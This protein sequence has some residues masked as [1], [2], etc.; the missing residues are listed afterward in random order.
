MIQHPNKKKALI[1]GGG[2]AG[3]TAAV[4]LDEM[5]YRITLLEAKPTL[6]GRAYSFLDKKTGSPV[7]NGQHVMIGAYHETIKLLERVG[8]KHTIK[9]LIPTRI[10]IKNNNNKTTYFCLRPL[11]FPFNLALAFLTFKG[12][13]FKDKINLLKL[14]KELHR[15]KTHKSQPPKQITVQ[16]WLKKFNQSKDAIQN[17]W[18]PLTLATLNNSVDVAAAESLC[19][20]FLK[21]YCEGKNDGLLIIPKKPL[22]DVFANPISQYIHM[23]GH[24][25]KLQA[26]VT[27]ISFLDHKVQSFTLSNGDTLKADLYISAMPPQ[28]L[29]RVLPKTFKDNHPPLSKL[30]Q[31]QKS[32]II[33]VDLFYD[34]CIMTDDFIGSACTTFQW[35]FRKTTNK[36]LCHV[37]G[38]ISGAH[39]L[40]DNDKKDLIATAQND[41]AYI[42]PKAKT[43]KL[44]HALAH[45]ERGATIHCH[46]DDSDIRPKQKQTDNFYIVGDWT[47]THLPPTIESATKSAQLMC[48]DLLETWILLAKNIENTHKEHIQEIK[49]EEKAR[50]R[51]LVFKIASKFLKF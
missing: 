17:F 51:Y 18:D 12:L 32:P 7:D 21:S 43:A 44:I 34:Q 31:F 48:D 6:G 33:S 22:Q 27:G 3:L 16:E 49:E 30:E 13:S 42:Y 36:G 26:R 11:S 1:A 40:L 14:A 4:L 15:I 35:F 38:L 8:A 23:R 10:P 47:Q 41:L 50:V 39:N 45:R 25:I 20:V 9:K 24:D 29:A 5:G 2:I 46:H 28:D 19:Q 37:T